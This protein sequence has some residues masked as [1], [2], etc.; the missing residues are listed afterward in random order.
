MHS[1]SPDPTRGYSPQGVEAYFAWLAQRMAGRRPGGLIQRRSVP[2]PGKG[3]VH[4]E[5]SRHDR[6]AQLA[7]VMVWWHA[8]WW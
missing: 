7:H 1:V 6:C 4:R 2:R 8:Q 3:R 5:R